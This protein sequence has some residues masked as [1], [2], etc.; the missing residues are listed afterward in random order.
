MAIIYQHL[1]PNGEVFYIGIGKSKK[2]ALSKHNRSK[3]W[4]N[5][6]NKY[7]YEVRI[8]KSDLSWGEAC[9]L[10]RILISWYGRLDLETGCLVNMT[11]GGEGSLNCKFSEDTLKK[12]SE[13]MKGKLAGYK[14]PMFGKK[15][16]QHPAF[17]YRQSEE[18][19]KRREQKYIKEK[20]HF[21]N[22]K[23]SQEHKDK[24]SKA[25]LGR[26]V[27]EE[28]IKKLKLNHA[29]KKDNYIPPTLG[30]SLQKRVILNR[31]NGIFYSTVSEASIIYS[32]KLSTLTA[33]LNGRNINKTNLIYC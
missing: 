28:T 22:K 33:M 6:V 3:Y 9:E 25:G 14:N 11:D 18:N 12:K 26:I 31:E 8:L 19:K 15:A 17:G 32:I 21:F 7:D 10:E 24:I 5:I 30:K 29:S 16:E 27:S 23:F 4:L 2:R 13:I 1:K 20:H